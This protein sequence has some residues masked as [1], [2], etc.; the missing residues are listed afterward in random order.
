MRNERLFIPQL[1]P[2]PV[3]VGCGSAFFGA[4]YLVWVGALCGELC[5][6]MFAIPIF[7]HEW[8]L[9]PFLGSG[10]TALVA[11]V[12]LPYCSDKRLAAVSAESFMLRCFHLRLLWLQV[13]QRGYGTLVSCRAVQRNALGFDNRVLGINYGFALVALACHRH[14][15]YSC[16]PTPFSG[17][18]CLRWCFSRQG[19]QRW[20]MGHRLIAYGPYPRVI[21]PCKAMALPVDGIPK[22]EI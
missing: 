21:S 15:A 3:V 10:T 11:A 1:F 9:P 17:T 19:W 12:Y 13:R 6:A 18:S 22:T 16:I 7:S 2:L 14:N 4:V 8:G 20:L 5:A